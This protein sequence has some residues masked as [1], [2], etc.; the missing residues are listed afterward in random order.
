MEERL[1]D[2][3]DPE[4]LCQRA[5]RGD[6]D[7]F[8]QL[9]YLFQKKIF[10]LAMSILR[11]REEALEVVQETFMKLYLSLNSYQERG[12]FETWLMRIAKNVAID[13]YRKLRS[14]RRWIEEK[15]SL[16]SRQS[17]L[18]GPSNHNSLSELR[19]LVD[20]AIS[21][22]AEKQRIV[23]L[24]RYLQGFSFEEI[25]CVLG[26]SVGTVKSLHFK[27]FQKMK[28]FIKRSLKERKRP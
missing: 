28:A 2:Y 25:A 18:V 24:L 6:R 5:K 23:F 1:A 15:E 26:L 3:E 8:N 4:V 22:L 7:S 9:V 14:Q 13:H 16:S 10:L 21:N 19:P 12:T 27:A 11:H 17:L 20:Q